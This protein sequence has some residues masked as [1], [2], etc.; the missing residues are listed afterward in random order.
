M[1]GDY[2]LANIMF[3]HDAGGVAAIVDW[4]M[5]TI[6]DPLLDLGWLTS[7]GPS[8]DA[9]TSPVESSAALPVCLPP[10]S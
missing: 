10:P 9:P 8:R 1:H 6:G 4:E 3:R 2:H 5:A 7:R